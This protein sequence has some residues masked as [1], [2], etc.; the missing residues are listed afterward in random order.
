MARTSIE[1][2]A[3]LTAGEVLHKR[4]SALPVTA[5]IG[6]VRAWFGASPHRRMAFLADGDRYAG[7]LTPGDLDGGDDDRGAA[8]IAHPGPTVD[9]ASPVS[10][11]YELALATDARRIPVVDCDGRLLGVMSVTEDEQGFC[12]TG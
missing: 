4:F 10:V 2:A 6:E 12:G 9:P 11:G 7:S 1:D 8:E 3:G 5:T